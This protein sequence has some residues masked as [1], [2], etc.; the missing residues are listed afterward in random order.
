MEKDKPASQ[1]HISEDGMLRLQRPAQICIGPG[2]PVAE[3]DVKSVQI[4][5]IQSIRT[6]G[7]LSRKS[8]LLSKQ[9]FEN[10]SRLFPIVIVAA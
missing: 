7:H 5:H 10:R 2:I 3:N 6:E 1:F 4:V 8:I 9:V